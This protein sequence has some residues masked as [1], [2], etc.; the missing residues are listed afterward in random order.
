M[1][2]ATLIKEKCLNG[3]CLQFHSLVHFLHGGEHGGTQADMVAESF[4]SGSTSNRK[5]EPLCLAWAFETPKPTPVKHFPNKAT[6][7]NPS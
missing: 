1:T 2:N 6:P 3:N 7:S 4:T 5:R